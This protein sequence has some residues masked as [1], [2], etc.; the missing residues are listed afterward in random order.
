MKPIPESIPG[1]VPQFDPGRFPEP[2]LE[3]THDFDAWLQAALHEGSEPADKGFQAALMAALPPQQRAMPRSL[4]RTHGG[5]LRRANVL[6]KSLAKALAMGAVVVVLALVLEPA[7]ALPLLDQALAGVS[8]LGLL[9]WW[10][11][12]QLRGGGWR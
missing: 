1:S 4:R 10:S 9:L 11:L 8:L 6:A 12:P 5:S 3:L 7:A 2:V